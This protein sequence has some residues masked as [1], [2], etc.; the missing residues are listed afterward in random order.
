M[1]A[2]TRASLFT[3]HLPIPLTQPCHVGPAQTLHFQQ[4]ASIHVLALS[5]WLFTTH[6]NALSASLGKHDLLFSENILRHNV[7]KT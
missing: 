7:S 6:M 4:Y 3:E 1:L 5:P 2:M